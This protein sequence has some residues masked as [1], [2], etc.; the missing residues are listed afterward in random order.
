MMHKPYDL[1]RL[2]RDMLVVLS[3]ALALLPGSARWLKS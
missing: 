3:L 2:S 1:P